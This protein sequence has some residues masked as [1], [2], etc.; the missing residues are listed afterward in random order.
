LGTLALGGA[1]TYTGA[2]AI[3]DDGGTLLFKDGG[4]L[5]NNPNTITVGQGATLRLDNTGTQNLADRLTDQAA[6]TL[7][8]AT[9]SF[10]GAGGAGFRHARRQRH[11]PG[12]DGAAGLGVRDQ[13]GRRRAGQQRQAVRERGDDLEDG[14]RPA[15]RAR[16]GRQRR[17]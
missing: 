2:T 15:A 14:Q 7:T 12:R 13:P 4:T 6:I 8:N 5:L 16:R 17:R 1:N 3:S 11:R 10:I 9:L